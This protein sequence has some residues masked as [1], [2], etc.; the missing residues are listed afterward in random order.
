MKSVCE[1]L[2]DKGGI[3]FC[4]GKPAVIRTEMD[5]KM[6]DITLNYAKDDEQFPRQL[7]MFADA[8]RGKGTV[9]ATGEQGIMMMRLLDAIYKSSELDQEVEV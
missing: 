4:P 5:G 6:A 2:G 7:A 1:F 8:V 9:P 3:K